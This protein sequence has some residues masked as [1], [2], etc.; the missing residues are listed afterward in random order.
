[1]LIKIASIRYNRI[2]DDTYIAEL[3]DFDGKTQ[4]TMEPKEIEVGESYEIQFG[5]PLIVLREDFPEL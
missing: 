3:V 2:D 5:S 4:I 1:M